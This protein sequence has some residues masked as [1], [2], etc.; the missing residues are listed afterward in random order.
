MKIDQ[1]KLNLVLATQCKTMRDL[2]PGISPNTSRKIKAGC[3]VRPDVVGR[4]A[5]I[6]NVSVESISEV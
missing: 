6:L 5:R 3:E 1:T 2:I 4:I